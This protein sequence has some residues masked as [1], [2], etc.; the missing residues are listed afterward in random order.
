MSVTLNPIF[1]IQMFYLGAAIVA[2]VVLGVIL[3]F[4]SKTP[5]Q[6]DTQSGYKR[7]RLKW[8]AIPILIY[9]MTIIL[10]THLIFIS[11]NTQTQN[12]FLS[13]YTIIG[14]AATIALVPLLSTWIRYGREVVFKGVIKQ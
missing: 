5:V 10:L 3:Y 2:A 1:L 11:T 7:F 13:L 14:L 12:V 9:S 6:W 4:N 8:S